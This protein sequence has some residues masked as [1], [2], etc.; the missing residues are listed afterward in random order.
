MANLRFCPGCRGGGFTRTQVHYNR[1]MEAFTN[2]GIF[3][4][5]ILTL[6]REVEQEAVK[7]APK[8]TGRMAKNHYRSVPPPRGYERWFFVGNR[9]GYARFVRGG[10]AENGAG[11]ITG[12]EGGLYNGVMLMRPAPY[13]Y[14]GVDDTRRFQRQV[15]GQK[16]NDWLGRALKAVVVRR[17]N[18]GA[19]RR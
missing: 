19:R 10:T 15:K 13:S 8:R 16:A 9:A 5:D 2:N 3:G 12:N 4:P 1:I 18:A 6:A 11:Y 7:E 14:F 17:I